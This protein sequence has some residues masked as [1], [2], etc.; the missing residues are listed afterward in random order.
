MP[1]PTPAFRKSDDDQVIPRV[2]LRAMLAVA[3]ASLALTAFA[4]VTDRPRVGQPHASAVVAERAIV[5]H[6]GGARAV[7]VRHPDGRVLAALDQ[8]GFVTVVE[9]GLSYERA[10]HG[11]A[12]GLPVRLVAYENGRL[13]IHDPET[14]W[15]VELGNFG[16]DNKAA[17][18]RLLSLPQ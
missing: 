13:A 17:F 15:S 8:G 5:L 3:L 11:I 7:T 1:S 4:V 2:L 14:G 6:G 10:R 16:A 18:E 12:P 9:N